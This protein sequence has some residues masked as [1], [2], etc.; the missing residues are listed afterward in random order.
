MK[1]SQRNRDLLLLF[2]VCFVCFFWQLGSVSLFDF[3]EGLY[4]EA[5]REMYL[6][7]DLV[8]P[9]AN[10]AFFFDKPP[11]V[12][13]LAVGSFHLFGVNEFA[14]RLPVAI[15]ATL[16]VFL[17]YWFGAKFLCCKTG[18][19]AGVILALCPIFFFTARQMT[20][21]IV[22]SLFFGAA[23]YVFF[24]AYTANDA[25]TRR[26]YYGFWLCCGFGYL[27]KSIPGLFPI[28]VAFAFVVLQERFDRRAICKR[29]WEAR[30][31]AGALILFLVLAPWHYL[32]YKAN[33]R[34][35]Y[36][37]YWVL[38]HLKLA[39]GTDFSHSQPWYFYAT[40]LVSGILPWSF[41][42]PLALSNRRQVAASSPS[43]GSAQLAQTAYRFSAVWAI[44]VV[45]VFSLMRSKLISYLIPMY[46]A[47][48]LLVAEWQVRVTDTKW[49]P[50]VMSS[51]L[52]IIASL[53]ITITVVGAVY[54]HRTPS[55]L[56]AQAYDFASAWMWVVQGMVVVSA[57]IAVAFG[58]SVFGK[59]SASVTAFTV[60]VFSFYLIASVRGIPALESTMNGRLHRLAKEAGDHAL[61]GDELAVYIGQPRRPSVFF[62]MPDLLFKSTPD[63]KPGTEILM[64]CSE[65]E[66]M[67][68][69]LARN[70]PCVILTDS[71]RAS[72]LM[73]IHQGIM[74][75]DIADK[76]RLLRSVPAASVAH[77]SPVS[78][79]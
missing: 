65:P 12:L 29:I 33:G 53:S 61:N 1:I 76:W 28:L 50:R 58:L 51:L 35:F 62:Y 59:Q 47:A 55:S 45:V 73:G 42:I 60:A 5:A 13:W 14:A 52:G 40:A 63:R 56:G 7:A 66:K 79:Q 49:R 26:W 74:V 3:N 21:D 17:T 27:A 31:I 20:M 25:R 24:V 57:G 75:E 37:E 39:S 10:G 9:V 41:F 6:R 72:A 77:K 18:L 38:H 2:A 30:P 67:D 68:A 48:A 44:V 71:K 16:L 78:L 64:E 70:K 36:E 69:F 8:T 43:D 4:V 11:L 46:P 32:A 34:V 15:S 54:I 22:Q 19:L 23:L